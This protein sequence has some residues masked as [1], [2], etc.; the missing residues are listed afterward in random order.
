M[1]EMSEVVRLVSGG[2]VVFL[3]VFTACIAWRLMR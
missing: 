2:G 1:S 3:A